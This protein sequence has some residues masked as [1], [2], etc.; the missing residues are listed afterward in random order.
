MFAARRLS[1]SSDSLA[2]PG[3]VNPTLLPA[4]SWIVLIGEFFLTLH[5]I[6]PAVMTPAPII[7]RSSPAK[8]A[9]IAA[10]VAT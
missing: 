7:L 3:C 6:V 10:G 5:E 8:I 9:L 1:A 4:R 2:D